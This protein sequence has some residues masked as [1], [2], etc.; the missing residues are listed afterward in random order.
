MSQSS[1]GSAPILA[2]CR[3]KPHAAIGVNSPPATHRWWGPGVLLR[4][5]V[6]SCPTCGGDGHLVVL[7][8]YGVTAET[9]AACTAC[10]GSGIQH[11]LCE[12]CMTPLERRTAEEQRGELFCPDCA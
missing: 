12:S 1:L 11:A 9:D 8:R 2:G 10:R 4:A 6:R 3:S 7:P 5:I